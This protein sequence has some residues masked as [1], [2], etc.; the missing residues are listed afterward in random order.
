MQDAL[1]EQMMEIMLR[2]RKIYSDFME[3]GV[4]MG[5]LACLSKIAKRSETDKGM[6]ISDFHNDLFITKP[7]FSQMLNSLERKGWIARKIDHND[8]R[9]ILVMLTGDGFRELEDIRDMRENYF[10]ELAERFGE[11]NIQKLTELIRRLAD[12]LE[13]IKQEEKSFQ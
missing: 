5:E 12:V 2:F 13:E 9:K 4:N 1:R 8:R 10:H 6:N 3:S 11:E 7:A